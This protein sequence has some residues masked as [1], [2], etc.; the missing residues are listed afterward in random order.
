MEESTFM[1][2]IRDL[3]EDRDIRIETNPGGVRMRVY[4][5]LL[6]IFIGVKEPRVK[7][8]RKSVV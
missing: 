3:R 4:T 7:G 6:R 5:R 1:V 2:Q 8:D